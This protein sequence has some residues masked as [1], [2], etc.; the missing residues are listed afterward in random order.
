MLATGTGD[1]AQPDHIEIYDIRNYPE[2]QN[3][4][5]PLSPQERLPA[6]QGIAVGQPLDFA[7]PILALWSAEDQKSA[8]AVSLNLQ[9]GMYEGS[10]LT[11]SCG[12]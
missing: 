1:S 8:R 6:P 9:T 2:S 7:G 11:V 12:H 5:K 4:T 3:A 10:I